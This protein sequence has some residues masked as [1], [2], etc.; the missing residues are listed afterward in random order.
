MTS[1]TTAWRVGRPWV[2]LAPSLLL[3]AAMTAWGVVR[4]PEL[5]ERVPEHIGVDGVD[6]W[7]DK[8]VGS[9][10]LPVFVYA[11]VTV[12]VVACAVGA[13]RVTPL[14]ELP[15]PEP[16]ERWAKATSTT[17]GRPASAASARRLVRALLAMNVAFGL[18]FLPLCWTQWRTTQTPDVPGW[19]LPVTLVAFLVSLAPLGVAWWRDAEERSASRTERLRP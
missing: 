5:P 17:N 7:A 15:E 6:A 18:A 9:V 8:S 3:L 19:I 1:G 2:W 13:A 11:L 4:Y 12:V 16:G 14:D 10:F